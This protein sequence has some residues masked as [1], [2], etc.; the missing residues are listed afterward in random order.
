MTHLERFG[1][2]INSGMDV[3]SLTAELQSRSRKARRRL[4]AQEED[5]TPSISSLAS[6]IEITRPPASI[7][8]S[9]EQ[10]VTGTDSSGVL[11]DNHLEASNFSMPSSSISQNWAEEFSSRIT[12][13]S[14]RVSTFS[15]PSTSQLQES[16]LGSPRSHTGAYLSDSFM[17]ESV[18][19]TSASVSEREHSRVVCRMISVSALLFT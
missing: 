3:E 9:H 10:S 5:V 1:N 7:G 12:E 14:P 4:S 6:S 8:H 17:S 2:T 15:M 18:A 16:V 19:S 11:V 13:S